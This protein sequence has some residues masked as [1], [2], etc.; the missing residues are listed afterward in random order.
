MRLEADVDRQY[1]TLYW[2]VAL[3]A[4][5]FPPRDAFR[6][7]T[8]APGQPAASHVESVH[9]G[10]KRK[11]EPPPSLSFDPKDSITFWVITTAHALERH[12]N[13]VLK[14]LGVTFRQAEVLALLAIEG[15]MSQA[16]LAKRMCIEAPTLAGIVNRMELSGWIVREACPNDRRKKLIR[17][18]ARAQPI[19]AEMLEQAYRV[20]SRA[21]HGFE[22]ERLRRLIADLAAVQANLEGDCGPSAGR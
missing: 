4:M 21:G 17:P 7:T 9:M 14:P 15:V 13:V 6:G 3:L 18:T 5:R 8:L 20:R 19:W 10:K 22:S 16:E 12:L 2:I 1:Q 11:P